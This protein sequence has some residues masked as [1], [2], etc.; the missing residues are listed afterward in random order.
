MDTMIVKD[1]TLLSHA[2]EYRRKAEAYADPAQFSA[3][4]L[5][6][7]EGGRATRVAECLDI[8]GY[9]ERLGRS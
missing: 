4:W 7:G 2:A 3:R 9:F 6:G 1:A 5:E 8:A